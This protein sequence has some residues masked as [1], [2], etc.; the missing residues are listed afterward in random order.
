MC[1]NFSFEKSIFDA[2]RKVNGRKGSGST[3][4]PIQFSCIDYFFFARKMRISDNDKKPCTHGYN[5]RT[6]CKKGKKFSN[7]ER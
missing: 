4:P 3:D 6:L 2:S 7:L 5:P 1:Q